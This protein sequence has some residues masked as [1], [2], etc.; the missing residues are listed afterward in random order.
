[1]II[2][3]TFSPINLLIR[4]WVLQHT[5]RMIINKL[6]LCSIHSIGHRDITPYY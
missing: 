4:I 6:Y 1:M 2:A 3:K 5:F